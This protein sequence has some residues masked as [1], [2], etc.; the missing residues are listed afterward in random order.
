VILGLVTSAYLFWFRELGYS[1]ALQ[2][3]LDT[4]RSAILNPTTASLPKTCVVESSKPIEHPWIGVGTIQDEL[5]LVA[6][7]GRHV[8]IFPPSDR[9][10][11]YSRLHADFSGMNMAYRMLRFYEHHQ[12]DAPLGVVYDDRLIVSPD[13]L[14]SGAMASR[15]WRIPNDGSPSRMF[16]RVSDEEFERVAALPNAVVINSKEH[17]P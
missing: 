10:D 2:S 15:F 8:V 17:L 13:M 5:A 16:H 1:W 12:F 11:L 7:I 3:H 6:A 9:P 14:P 4:I